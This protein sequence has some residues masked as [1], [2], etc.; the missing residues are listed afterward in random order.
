MELFAAVIGCLIMIVFVI[1]MIRL[2][3]K[4]Y[5]K[6]GLADFFWEQIDRHA[7]KKRKKK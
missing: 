4:L 3:T 7:E 6:S 1:G 5:E 2:L